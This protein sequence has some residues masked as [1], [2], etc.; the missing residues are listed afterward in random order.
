MSTLVVKDLCKIYESRYGKTKYQALDNVSF[1]VEKGEYIAVMGESGS[2]KTTLLNMLAGLDDITSGS[3]LLEGMDL[4]D[5]SDSKMAKFRRENLGFVFQD[6]SLLDFFTL[7]DNILLPTVLRGENH[8]ESVEKMMEIAKTLE[9]DGLLDKYPYEV[10]G[11]QKQ[12]AAVARAIIV[13]PKMLLA[14]EPTGALD[15]KSTENL[16][17]IFDILNK[18]GQ[19]IFMV[20]HSVKAA[21]RAGQL[22]IIKDGRLHDRLTKTEGMSNKEFEKVIMDYLTKQGIEG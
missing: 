7:K 12:R 21:C 10:S 17:D 9:I 22:L 13:D 11:G 5:I 19:T 16:L 8:K 6:F 4:K 3:V 14:D 18:Q 15:S 1:T 2:G 20:T